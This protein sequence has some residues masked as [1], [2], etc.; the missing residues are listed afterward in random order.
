MGGIRATKVTNFSD[1]SK[2]LSQFRFMAHLQISQLISAP[3]LE[4]F[5]FLT[6]P[7]NLPLLLRP[8][9]NVQVVSPDVALKRGNEVHFMMS[10]FGLSQSIRFRIEDILRGSRLSYRQ[11]EGVF[12]SWNHTIKF[13]EHGESGTLV[14]DLVDYQVPMGL[15]G[16]LA[17]DLILKR[18]MTRLLAQRLVRA[19]HYLGND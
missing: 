8:A 3:R 13:D 9:V 6:D 10:R 7:N 15:I 14:T 17:D 16:H 18:D 1:K 12:A 11:S 19:N 4:V 2:D 5:D